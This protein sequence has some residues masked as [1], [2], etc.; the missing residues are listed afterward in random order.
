[1][2]RII[3]YKNLSEEIQNW[4]TNYVNNYN[5]KTLVIGVSGGIDSA[6]VST[7]C[8]KTGIPTISVGMPLNS[9][10]ENTRLS[11]LQL[12]FLSKLNVKTFEYDLTKTFNSFEGLMSEFFNS[13]LSIANSKSRMRMM[14]LYHIATTVKGI[15]VGTGNKVEDFGVG[16]YTKYGDGGVDISPIADIYKTEVRELGRYLGVPQEIINATPTDG[17]W[18][19]DRNDEEQIGAT[20]EELE[21]V[22]EYGIDKQSYTDKEIRV[23]QI[24]QNFNEKNKHK[25]VPIPIFDLKENKII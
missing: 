8:A 6:V 18:D 10:P 1:M 20:Y 11:N 17:L 24:Y 3:D 22:M 14:T 12:D 9:K 16:F 15:V 13:D 21:W 5:I 4:I 25:M 19:D 23:L 7:L 2:N